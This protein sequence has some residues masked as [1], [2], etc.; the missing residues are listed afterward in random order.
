MVEYG[1]GSSGVRMFCC[2]CLMCV[3]FSVVFCVVLC[4]SCS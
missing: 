4:S 2:F 3:C 1:V